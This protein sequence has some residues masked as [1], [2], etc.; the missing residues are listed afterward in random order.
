MRRH[1]DASLLLNTNVTA[2][3]V[4]GV[5]CEGKGMQ[6]CKGRK[7]VSSRA[8]CVSNRR[9]SK[10]NTELLWARQAFVVSCR[11]YHVQPIDIVNIDYA[12]ADQ[13]PLEHECRQVGMCRLV[14]GV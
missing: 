10:G 9:R 8:L 7:F 14:A 6:L 13:T 5:P 12:S 11:A 4:G 1:V 2:A 3:L